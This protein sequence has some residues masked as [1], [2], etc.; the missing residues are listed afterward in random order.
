MSPCQP[1][2]P[3]ADSEACAC[4]FYDSE[5]VCFA[6]EPDGGDFANWTAAAGAWVDDVAKDWLGDWWGLNFT[7]LTFA[8]FSEGKGLDDDAWNTFVGSYDTF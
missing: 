7:A 1:W 4:S 8:Q 5:H 6:G 2:A 3:C